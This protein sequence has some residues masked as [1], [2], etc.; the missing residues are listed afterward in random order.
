MASAN[1]KHTAADAFVYLEARHVDKLTE[2]VQAQT[3]QITLQSELSRKQI[4]ATRSLD[5]SITRLADLLAP[6]GDTEPVTPGGTRRATPASGTDI[7]DRR[8]GK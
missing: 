4:E 2:A 1:G 7:V 5:A 8:K 3:R 6:H